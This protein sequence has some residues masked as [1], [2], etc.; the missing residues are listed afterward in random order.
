MNARNAR[1][2]SLEAH[3]KVNLCL[4]VQYPPRDGYHFVRTVMQ[5]LDLH[6]DLRFRVRGAS[7]S[8]RLRTSM[9]S[10]IALIC[11]VAG[12]SAQDNLIFK[13]IDAA[14]QAF[15]LPVIADGQELEIQVEKRIPAGGGLGGGSSNAAAALK[16]YAQLVGCDPQ[17]ERLVRVARGLGADVAFFMYGQAALMGG[18][19]DVFEQSLPPLEAPIV[20]MGD[21]QG[22]STASVYREFDEHPIPA[23]DADALVQAM[24]SGAA[25]TDRVAS[26]CANNLGPIARSLSPRIDQRVT[27]A[28]RQPGVLNALV[29]GSGATSFA[30]CSDARSA[31]ALV[32][33]VSPS[34]DWVRICRAWP[35]ASC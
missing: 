7:S 31:E 18:R 6:D 34:C 28:L 26:L 24:S 1:A 23:P 11:D 9:G 8:N 35:L 22:M 30:I 15:A 13:A 16:A 3:A 5:E 29:S 12:L 14:E 33:A 19:G 17:D 25:N 2:F 4:A 21:A 10:G 32:E 27:E 20:L